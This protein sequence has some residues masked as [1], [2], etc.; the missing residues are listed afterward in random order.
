[1]GEN[2]EDADGEP[3]AADGRIRRVR[4]AIIV[5]GLVAIPVGLGGYLTSFVFSR[6][7][8][9][10]VLLLGMGCAVLLAVLDMYLRL[11]EVV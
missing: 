2:T 9:L 5:A 4:L 10:V 7:V 11:H 3:A 1:M 8:Y 6:T